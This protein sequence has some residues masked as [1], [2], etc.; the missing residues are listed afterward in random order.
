[1]ETQENKQ[2]RLDELLE[3]IPSKTYENVE[4][5]LS[6]MKFQEKQDH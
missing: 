3:N 4:E 5:V 6:E 2:I 1:M